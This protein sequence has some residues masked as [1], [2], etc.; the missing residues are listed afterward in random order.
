MQPGCLT[1]EGIFFKRRERFY[2]L[3]DLPDRWDLLK[4]DFAR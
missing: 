2:A 3:I 1:E 4:P